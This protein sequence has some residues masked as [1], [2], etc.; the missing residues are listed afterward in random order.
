MLKQQRGVLTQ[1]QIDLLNV[2]RLVGSDL[3]NHALRF[4]DAHDVA[5]LQELG[6]LEDVSPRV[7][8]LTPL[9]ESHLRAHGLEAVPWDR[10]RGETRPGS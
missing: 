5:R 4:L 2:A 7:I 10:S 1:R 3:P 8:L 9:G 6:L